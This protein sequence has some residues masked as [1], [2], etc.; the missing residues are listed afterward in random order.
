MSDSPL[1][2]DQARLVFVGTGGGAHVERCHACV[3]LELSSQEVVLLDTAGGF[4]VIRNLEYA[5]VDLSAIKHIFISHRHSDHIGGLEPLLLHIGLHALSTKRRAGVVS[6]YAHSIVIR[7]AQII[8]EAMASAA[9]ALLRMT[10]QEIR[11][12]ALEPERAVELRPGVQLTPFSVD[13]EPLDGSHLGC[14]LD[15]ALDE[16]HWSLV[17]SGDTRPVAALQAHAAGADVLLHEAGGVD[18]NAAIVH[19]SGHTTAA[20]AARLARTAGVRRLY[21]CHVPHEAAIPAMLEE[22]AHHYDG[23]VRVPSD[24]ESVALSAFYSQALPAP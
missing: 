24:L 13:H 9:P 11:W 16:R 14:R 10:E 8:L 12:V 18:A 7:A 2:A 5:R 23:L 17:Y 4:Q 1:T 21:L 20:E 15:L 22:A 6:V 19:V 3:A